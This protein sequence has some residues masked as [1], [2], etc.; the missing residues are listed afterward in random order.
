VDASK[1]YLKENKILSRI[2]FK[3]SPTHT[4]TLEKDKLETITGTDGQE[5]AGVQY[6][7][8]EDGEFKTW[9]TGSPSVIQKIAEYKS[10]D[11][12][13]V[14]MKS[15]KGNQGQFISV[16]EVELVEKGDGEKVEDEEDVVTD[17]AGNEVNIEDIPF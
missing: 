7:V 6:L 14:T 10:G 13:K 9:F 4:F 12:V 17:D 8:Q 5:K 2:S 1:K 3:E 15:V 11:T 16:F